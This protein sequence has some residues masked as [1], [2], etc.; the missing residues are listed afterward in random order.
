[1]KQ[2]NISSDSDIMREIDA[3]NI[4]DIL[5][6]PGSPIRKKPPPRKNRKNRRNLPPPKP[7]NIPLEAILESNDIEPLPPTKSPKSSHIATSTIKNPEL[8]STCV[9][10][11]E[12]RLLNY[13]SSSFTILK[14]EIL[15]EIKMLLEYGDKS[16]HI[17]ENFIQDFNNCLRK[18]ITYDIQQIEIP[19]IDFDLD[20]EMPKQSVYPTKVYKSAYTDLLSAKATLLQ[21]I[22]NK[23]E[24]FSDSLRE[25][26]MARSEASRKKKVLKHRSHELRSVRSEY[27]NKLVYLSAQEERIKAD[28]KEMQKKNEELDATLH[29]RS[30]ND[31]LRYE[32]KSA[33]SGIKKDVARQHSN[34]TTAS[35]FN[36]VDQMF[37]ELSDINT[38]CDDIVCSS[39]NV[40][41]NILTLNA[42]TPTRP[43]IKHYNS[44]PPSPMLSLYDTSISTHR[45]Y[46]SADNSPTAER[47]NTFSLNTPKFNRK[48]YN[49]PSSPLEPEY[50]NR[51]NFL[52]DERLPLTPYV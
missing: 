12:V 21:T 27:E 16:N 46:Y 33:I 7:L 43:T 9:S 22:Q 24:E 45:A 25:R 40:V 26:D 2:I 8:T 51:Y 13:V 14:E 35:I 15:H 11:L 4:D 50:P 19:N 23:R 52:L 38:F 31:N 39:Q 3:L 34:R 5:L 20:I 28:I 30:E 37:E 36:K 29:Q 17:V 48:M 10:L 47:D 49:S 18:E 6:D 32:I 44:S 41:Q 42:F 1:M